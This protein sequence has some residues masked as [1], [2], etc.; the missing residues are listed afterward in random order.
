MFVDIDIYKKRVGFNPTLYLSI[1]EGGVIMQQ[2]QKAIYDLR[3]MNIQNCNNYQV[4]FINNFPTDIYPGEYFQFV[5]EHCAPFIIPY[6]Y[7]ISTFGRLFDR[8]RGV[9]INPTLNGNYYRY[10]YTTYLNNETD[11]I[12]QKGILAHRCVLM[13]FNYIPGCELLEVNHKDGNGFNNNISNLEWMTHKENIE[14]AR[15]NRFF[16]S[17]ENSPKTKITNELAEIICKRLE[18]G[19][20]IKSIS[21]D[22]SIPYHIVKDIKAGISYR[23]I[24]AKYD[25]PETNHHEEKF[26]DEEVLSIYSRLQSGESIKCISDDLGV[27]YSRIK[28]IKYKDTYTDLLHDL[29]SLDKKEYNSKMS[30][31]EVREICQLLQDG[32]TPN[33]ISKLLNVPYMSVDAIHKGVTFKY[34]SKDYTFQD[35]YINQR[36]TDNDVREM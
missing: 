8:E 20:S 2:V 25:L 22:M 33:D 13:T 11:C 9:Y 17:G 19:E 4:G 12:K 16:A 1:S 18:F 23:Y 26:T 6:R 31:S 7:M 24:G 15:I 27:T 34:I 29:P 28:S 5:F 14:H 30:E 32:K 10:V 36:L 35:R 21:D 3:E